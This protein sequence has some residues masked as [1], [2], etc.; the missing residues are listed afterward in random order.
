MVES[1][2]AGG[3]LAFAVV[4]LYAG[5]S[6]GFSAL[7]VSQEDVRADQ[8]LVEKLETLRVYDWSKIDA[9]FIPTSFTNTYSGASTPTG[10]ETVY[11]GTLS[12]VPAPITESYNN[13]LRQITVAL[14]WDSGGTTHN[15][16]MTTLVS[17]NGIHTV[18]P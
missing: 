18:L 9:S 12:I 3:I 10:G 1:L 15:R 14:S 6:F 4:S 13:T 7:K 11:T 17:Q 16:S 5:F 8:I 2:I